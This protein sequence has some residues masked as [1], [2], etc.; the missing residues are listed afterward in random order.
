MLDTINT[1]FEY[2]QTPSN[3]IKFHKNIRL[4]YL[5]SIYFH[6]SKF[7]SKLQT[8]L[9]LCKNLLQNNYMLY[10]SGVMKENQ[11]LE[12]QDIAENAQVAPA[13]GQMSGNVNFQKLLQYFPSIDPVIVRR[14]VNVVM[15]GG[16]LNNMQLMALGNAFVDLL[17]ASPSETTQIMNLMKKVS[18]EEG[19]S[20]QA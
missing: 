17:K 10:L 12:N 5:A 14:S 6:H 9:P 16:K 2:H 18:M 11:Y 7:D 19:D 4:F 8:I 1:L 20:P 3:T 13:Q 15:K